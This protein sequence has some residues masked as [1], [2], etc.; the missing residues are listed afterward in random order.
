MV[1]VIEA[2]LI[3]KAWGDGPADRELSMIAIAIS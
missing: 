2:K 1:K 3:A